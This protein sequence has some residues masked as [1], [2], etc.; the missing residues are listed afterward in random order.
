MDHVLNA[1]DKEIAKYTEAK[2]RRN[3]VE[4]PLLTPHPGPLD[5]PELQTCGDH[6]GAWEP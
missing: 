6:C 1:F 5:I 2:F 4:V 3:G